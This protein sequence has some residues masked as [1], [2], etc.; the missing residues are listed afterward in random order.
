MVINILL[1]FKYNKY[2]TLTLSINQDFFKKWSEVWSYKST[3]AVIIISVLI[4]IPLKANEKFPVPLMEQDQVL[5][6]FNLVLPGK[7]HWYLLSGGK[8]N[9]Y[10]SIL[11]YK[12]LNI[13]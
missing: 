2:T 8:I 6:F 3:N 12:S 1:R 7:E 10:C 9:N 4:Q 11:I 13:A 5:L